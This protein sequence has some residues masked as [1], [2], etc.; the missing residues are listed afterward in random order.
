[1][2]GFYTLPDAPGVGG[3]LTDAVLAK[4]RVA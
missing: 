3:K 4:H 1:V 2:D